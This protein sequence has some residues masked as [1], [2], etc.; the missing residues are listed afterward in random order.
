[1]SNTSTAIA[2]LDQFRFPSIGVD[3]YD[4][5]EYED[6]APEFPRVKIPAGGALAFELPNPDD[7]DDPIASKTI[8][9]VIVYQHNANAYWEDT[10]GSG[11]PPDCSSQD[12][13]TG[14]GAPG[15]ACAACPYNQF[16][17]G[18]GGL[19]KACKNM[20]NIYLLRDGDMLP[21][22][23][24]LPPTSLKA[25]QVYANNIRFAGRAL[26][27]VRTQV[28]LKK[29]EGNGNTYS[30]AVFRMTGT[31]APALAET[32]KQYAAEIRSSIK[33]LRA[34]RSAPEG[35]YNIPGASTTGSMDPETGELY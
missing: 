30:V 5:S 15:G 29:Q 3:A 26:S 25:F 9:G 33:Q 21:L 17:S 34:D 11:S 20:R 8:E 24:S 22:L 28:S 7:P 10:D 13:H 32:G 19:G 31:L 12:G 16:G 35:D 6:I 2:T 1:M 27:G 4:P 23:I 14:Y 18:E